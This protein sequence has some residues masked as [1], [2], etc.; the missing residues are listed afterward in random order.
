M[1][2]ALRTEQVGSHAWVRTPRRPRPVPA[3]VDLDG[4]LAVRVAEAALAE[5]PGAVVESVA[6]DGAGRFAARLRTGDGAR[7]VVRLDGRLR[8]RGWVAEVG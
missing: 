2:Q 3:D 6:V 1:R 5:H 4:A 7:V 8:V